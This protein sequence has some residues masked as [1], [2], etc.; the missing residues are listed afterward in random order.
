MEVQELSKRKGLKMDN[1]F[2]D[3]IDNE[4]KLKQKYDKKLGIYLLRDSSVFTDYMGYIDNKVVNFNKEFNLCSF[5]NLQTFGKGEIEEFIERLK[6]NDIYMENYD[7]LNYYLRDSY[8][9]LTMIK[10]ER[11]L[12]DF[13][14]VIYEMLKNMIETD[15]ENYK[16]ELLEKSK[17][18]FI[19]ELKAIENN[20]KTTNNNIENK[21][22]TLAN[23]IENDNVKSNK[24]AS[25][26]FLV[27]LFFDFISIQYTS[28]YGLVF[29]SFIAIYILFN[30]RFDYIIFNKKVKE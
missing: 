8:D 15:K 5:N 28:L 2:W 25:D 13:D 17:S 26:L 30:Y 24:K 23:N 14:S 29:T 6:E 1:Y 3:A 27:G 4:E 18:K 11:G 7:L 12:K 21:I 16:K 22:N 19:N 10:I 20:I 9:I